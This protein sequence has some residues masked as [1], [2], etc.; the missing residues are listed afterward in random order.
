V[1]ILDQMVHNSV[2]TAAKLCRRKGFRSKPCFTVTWRCLR[3]E[4]TN[5]AKISPCLYLT[6][7]VYSMFG[8][9]APVDELGK[10]LN[11]Y[12]QL[13]LYFDDAHGMSWT[14]K[15]GRGYVLDCLPIQ[16]AWLLQHHCARLSQR[17]AARLFFRMPRCIGRLK[18]AE[19]P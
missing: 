1:I 12:E 19:A 15:H 11:R 7:G 6:D 2:Q 14:G 8:D 10:L 17:E 3:R 18:I 9:M 13:H 4:S 16:N 5:L